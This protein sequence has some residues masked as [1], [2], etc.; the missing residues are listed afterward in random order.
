MRKF[1]PKKAQKDRLISSI[2][3][4]QSAQAV[5]EQTHGSPVGHPLPPVAVCTIKNYANHDKQHYMGILLL[6]QYQDV[7]ILVQK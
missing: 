5:G 1:C 3:K 7:T 6:R 4:M 2:L